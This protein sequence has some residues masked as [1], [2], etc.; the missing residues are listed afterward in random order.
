MKRSALCKKIAAIDGIG[1]ITA[2]A[3]LAAVGE[4]RGIA[5]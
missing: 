2:T 5:V 1:P 3:I 4:A